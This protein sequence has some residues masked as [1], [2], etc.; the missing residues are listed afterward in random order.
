MTLA[1]YACNMVGTVGSVKSRSDE[2]LF[3]FD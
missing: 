1:G 2:R 3:W